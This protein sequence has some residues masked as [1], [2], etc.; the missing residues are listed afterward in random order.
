[1]AEKINIYQVQ[2][3]KAKK[4]GVELYCLKYSEKNDTIKIY[5]FLYEN[6]TIFLH[7]KKDKFEEWFN[8]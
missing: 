7:R 6:A 4:D 2:P 8:G 1:M 5:N 3:S